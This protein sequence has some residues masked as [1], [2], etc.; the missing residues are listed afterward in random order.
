MLEDKKIVGIQN[1]EFIEECL[2]TRGISEKITDN[3]RYQSI[4]WKISN[5]LANAKLKAYSPEAKSLLDSIININDDG[6]IVFI[7]GNGKNSTIITCRYYIDELDGKLK[8]IRAENNHDKTESCIT[9]S[10]YNDDGIEEC[11]S[12]E[13]KTKYGSFL[14][15]ATRVQNRPDMI[16]IERVRQEKNKLKRLPDVYQ[17]RQFQV[18]LEDIYPSLEEVDP[19]DVMNFSILGIPEI[20]R[21]LTKEEQLVISKMNG[22]IYPLDETEREECFQKYKE[23]NKIYHR[24][25]AFEKGMAKS[26][27]VRNQDL[28]K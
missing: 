10:I 27:M 20:Y 23:L 15:K 6:S 28:D 21:D 17:I 14:S 13:Q 24:T 4:L 12:T 26:F 22:R 2:Y 1:R 5:L 18:G 3:P 25:R 7:E 19:Y 11:L 16:K 8:R 9:V